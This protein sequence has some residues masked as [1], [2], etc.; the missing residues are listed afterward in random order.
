[1]KNMTFLGCALFKG[2]F[3]IKNYPWVCCAISINFCL[4]NTNQLNWCFRYLDFAKRLDKAEKSLD[5][6]EERLRQVYESVEVNLQLIGAIGIEDRLQV[7]Y[8][9]YEQIESKDINQNQ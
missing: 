5:R 4:A 2:L 3:H 1:M 7:S 6:R 9:L 8:L